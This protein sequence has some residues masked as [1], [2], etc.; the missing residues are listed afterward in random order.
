VIANARKAARDGL[1]RRHGAGAMRGDN[2]SDSFSHALPRSG[3]KVARR[4]ERLSNAERE[5]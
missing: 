3:N 2:R 4:R 5:G 1:R